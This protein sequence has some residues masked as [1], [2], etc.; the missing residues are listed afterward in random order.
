MIRL[1]ES[2]RKE[3]ITSHS[4]SG[5]AYSLSYC[6]SCSDCTGFHK[7]KPCVAARQGERERERERERKGGWERESGRGIGRPSLD[8]SEFG[9]PGTELMQHKHIC[10]S[11]VLYE[12]VQYVYHFLGV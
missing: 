1:G 6:C 5:F 8:H 7:L 11:D 4:L 9:V 3:V 12:T 10:V 2:H